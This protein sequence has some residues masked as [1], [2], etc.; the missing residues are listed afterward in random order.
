MSGRGLLAAT[1]GL[2]VLAV[3]AKLAL[4]CTSQRVVDGDEAIVGL[5]ALHV[6]GHGDHPLFLYGQGYDLGAGVV[7]HLAALA[8][9]LGGVSD[10]SLKGTALLVWLVMATVVRRCTWLR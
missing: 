7:A 3:F 2:F 8:F 5:M 9:R 1:G 10:L 4:L 6:V